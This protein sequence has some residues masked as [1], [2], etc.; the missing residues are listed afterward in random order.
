[1]DVECIT[2]KGKA[3]TSDNIPLRAYGSG[4]RAGGA[5]GA[6]LLPRILEMILVR[7]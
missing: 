1:M 6:N 4:D 7:T 5:V 2:Y 3:L